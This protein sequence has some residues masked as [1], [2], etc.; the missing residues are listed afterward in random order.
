MRA[1]SV[2]NAALV[3]VLPLSLLFL[4]G[5]KKA[6][7]T[8]PEAKTAPSSLD[9]TLQASVT[10]APSIASIE[11]DATAPRRPGDGVQVTARAVVPAGNRLDV[12]LKGTG[13]KVPV[14]S[15]AE[16]DSYRG[17]ATIPQIPPGTYT[18]HGVVT[19]AGGQQVAQF[20]APIP[21]TIV[22]KTT[23]CEDAQAK[24]ADLRVPFDYDKADLGPNAKSVL[25]SVAA[26]LKELQPSGSEVTVEG[27]CDERGTVEYNLAL[28]NRR[29]A[30]VAGY[31]V[32]LGA[33]DREKARKVSFG[34]ERPRNPGH[35]ETAWA[36]NRRAEFSVACGTK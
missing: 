35:D 1:R 14:S 17:S 11:H 4:G 3:V 32:D 13:F 28:G 24:L 23:P 19:G 26:V 20:D 25:A 7:Q 10:R 27:H 21:I 9:V 12:E 31:L 5:C 6:P 34:K 16:P 18:L 30:A 22:P 29:A 2:R 15:T 33:V 8:V 36:E